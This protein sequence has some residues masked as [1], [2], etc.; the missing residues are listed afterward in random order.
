MNFANNELHKKT[1][2]S[3]MERKFWGL[4]LS[5]F[6]VGFAVV[7]A[8][9]LV[10]IHL[11]TKY[12]PLSGFQYVQWFL[13]GAFFG[14]LIVSFINLRINHLSLGGLILFYIVNILLYSIIFSALVFYLFVTNS[15]DYR[16]FL[17]ISLLPLLIIAVCGIIGYF[18]LLKQRFVA[19]LIIVFS[20]T[21]LVLFFVS[22]FVLKISWYYSLTTIVLISL[23]TISDFYFA[24]NDLKTFYGSSDVLVLK[25]SLVFGIR[26]FLN[27]MSLFLHLIFLFTRKN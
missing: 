13:Y 10:F 15:L 6:G 11:L 23:I 8:L 9:S 17:G 2:V 16:K 19:F 18:D 27:S 22:I 24:K 21:S 26:I 1:I 4:S 7:V 3:P 5:I 14:L 25:R 20:I 12:L